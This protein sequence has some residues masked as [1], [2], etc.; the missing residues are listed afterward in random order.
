MPL[1]A[2]GETV[3]AAMKKQYGAKKGSSVFYASVNKG[4]VTGAEK[5]PPARGSK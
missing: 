2:K 3:L 1:T 5:R 4:V